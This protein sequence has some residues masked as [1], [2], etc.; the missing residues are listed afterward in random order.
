MPE[1][2]RCTLGEA[3]KIKVKWAETEIR[4]LWDSVAEMKRLTLLLLEEEKCQ[5]K[6]LLKQ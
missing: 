1:T 6:P 5:K 3:N 4:R 2:E